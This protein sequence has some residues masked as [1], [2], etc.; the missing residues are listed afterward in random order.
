MLFVSLSGTLKQ[1]KIYFKLQNNVNTD[2][3]ETVQYTEQLSRECL[4]FKW[5]KR[6]PNLNSHEQNTSDSRWKEKSK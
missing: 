3:G 2:E 1:K 4:Y 5:N 6:I